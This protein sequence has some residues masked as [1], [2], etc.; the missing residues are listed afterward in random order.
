MKKLISCHKNINYLVIKFFG[1]KFKFKIKELGYAI[2]GENN[3]ILLKENGVTRELK[4]SEKIDGLDIQIN[5]NNNHITLESKHF[6]NCSMLLQC[7]N[8]KI[9]I[10]DN[11]RLNGLHISV[12]CGNFQKVKIGKNT[13]CFHTEVYLNEENASLEI[14]KDCMLS[15]NIVIWTT[16]GHAIIE[17]NTNK[18]INQPIKTVIGEHCWI[19]YGA[20]LCK[21][22]NLPNDVIVGA[23][24]VV[25]KAFEDSNVVIAGNPARIIKRNVQWERD[26]AT[27]EIRKR[28][29][30]GG[31]EREKSF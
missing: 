3:K 7:S 8:A 16:D 24:S 1:I 29:N 23:R 30:P 9:E 18:V 12:A 10:G 27:N 31:L 26:T 6:N 20:H 15:G 17:K 28:S 13:T 19:G 11:C 2:S 14:G 21:N 25:T 4:A 5:G 22:T